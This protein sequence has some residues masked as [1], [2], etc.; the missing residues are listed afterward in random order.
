M[1]LVALFCA[2]VLVVSASATP[3][4]SA[5]RYTYDADG[6]LSG[7][8]DP[9]A[10]AA[11]FE[12]DAV[13]NLL[14]IDRWAVSDLRVMQ[15]TPSAGAVGDTVVIEGTG[16]EPVPG[17]NEV[18]FNGTEATVSSASE[19]KLVVEVPASASTGP[20]SVE[21]AAGTAS[22][23]SPF[24]VIVVQP[25]TISG[26]SPTLVADGATT[27]VTGTN[28]K[29]AKTD[30]SVA[31]NRTRASIAQATSTTLDIEAPGF[32]A[33]GRVGVTT[34]DGHATGPYLFIPPEGYLTSEVAVT[35]TIPFGQATPAA[36]ASN[37]KIALLVFEGEANDRVSLR[38]L[39]SGMTGTAAILAPNGQSLASVTVSNG[40]ARFMDSVTLPTDGTYTVLVTRAGST[41][42][43]T[44][45]TLY[46]VGQDVTAQL[47]PSASGHAAT[48]T[49]TIPGQNLRAEVDVAEG[50]RFFFTMTG[51]GAHRSKLLG[52]DGST[53]V[54]SPSQVYNTNIYYFDT[55]R[56][57]EAGTYT[58]LV[59]P[60]DDSL[61]GTTVTAH[62]VAADEVREVSPIPA[63]DS[64]A[65]TLAIGQ[66]GKMTFDGEAG[67]KL[68]WR[69][70]GR[71]P[72]TLAGQL[73]LRNSAGDTVASE[74][75]TFFQEPVALPADGE[76]TLEVDPSD[77]KAGTLTAHL[78]D[79]P[80]DLTAEL[81]PIASG[82]SETLTPAAPGQNL[83]AQ[84]EVSE[85]DR[86]LVVLAGANIHR[87]T[88]L[89]PSGAVLFS[90]PTAAS[91]YYLY[92]TFEAPDDGLYTVTVDPDKESVAS[93]TISVYAVPADDVRE[94]TPTPSGA[95][96][97]FDLDPGQSG[98]MIFDGTAGQKVSW[99]PSGLSPTSLAGTVRLRDSS[100][101]VISSQSFSSFREP[102]TLPA[103][104]EYTLE[105]DP[106]T[107]QTGSL[108]VRLH[109]VPADVTAELDPLV[110]GDAETLT[111]LAPGQ[112]LRA[113]FDAT[114]G[115]RVLITLSGGAAS[116][117]K[118]LRPDGSVLVNSPT[119]NGSL[120]H[121]DTLT[122]PADGT[123]TVTV[124]PQDDSV[125]GTTVTAYAVPADDVRAVTPTP[126]GAAETFALDPGQMGRMTFTGTAGQK[127]SW[128]V[129][130]MTP[131]SLVGSVRLRNAAGG[132]V[133]SQSLPDFREPVTL[134]ANGEYTV[135][136]D[137]R[138]SESGTLTL[139]LHDVPT[140]VTATLT[141]TSTGDTET[142]APQAPGQNLRAEFAATA[143]DRFLVT[144]TGAN[145]SKSKV[146]RPDGSV[147][148]TSWGTI[149]GGR[150]FET[151]T[152]PTAGTHAVAVD[153]DADSTASTTITVYAVPAEI[154]GTLT[155]T[156]PGD[157]IPLTTTVGQ[158][159]ALTF[160]GTA[161]NKVAVQT[162]ASDITGSLQLKRPNGTVQASLSIASGSTSTTSTQT[163]ATTGTYTIA[164]DP[165]SI[166]AGNVTATLFDRTGL[167]STTPTPPATTFASYQLPRAQLRTVSDGATF[168]SVEGAKKSRR[169]PSTSQ[170][171]AKTPTRSNMNG[172]RD[173]PAR[174]A[175]PANASPQVPSDALLRSVRSF[176]PVASASWT[177]SRDGARG[178][179]K[180]TEP[181]SPLT[182]LPALQAPPGQTALTGQVLKVNG[183]PLPNARIQLDDHDA[184]TRTDSTGRFLLETDEAG[185]AVLTVEGGTV[186][187]GL[188]SFGSYRMRIDLKAGETTALEAPVWLTK[189][190]RAGDVSIPKR[191]AKKTT[192]TNP[193]IPGFRVEIPAGS[194]IRD[195]NGEPLSRIN[196]TAIPLDRPPFPLP[197]FDVPAYFTL[198][199]AGAYLSKGAR[200]IYPNYM[201]ASP[202]QRL[203]F[204]NYDAE[205][206]GW[207]V[208]GHGRV[209]DDA[210]RMVP[211][212]GVRIWEFTGAMIGNGTGPPDVR[213]PVTDELSDGD[214]VEL[215][216]G[217]F[218]DQH[219]DL[220]VDDVIPAVAHRTYRTSDQN[221]YDFGRGT[222][223]PYDIRLWAPA[224]D[225]I[226]PNLITPRGAMVH[227]GLTNPGASASDRVFKPEGI[228]GQFA[229]TVLRRTPSGFDLE[230]RDGRVYV[231]GY[232][233]PL[234]AIK[235]AAGNQL[236]ITRSGGDRGRV[237][238]V[239]T[240]N[241]RWIRFSHDSS[242][243]TTRAVD[244]AGREVLYEY[245]TQNLL[246]EVT[247]VNG[248]VSTRTYN[249]DGRL[250]ELTDARGITYLENTYYGGRVI[251][252][253]TADGGIYEFDYDLRYEP[254][255]MKVEETRVT[256]PRGAVRRATFGALWTSDT[257]AYG[258]GIQQSTETQRDTETGRIT[259]VTD[260][261]D[262][263]TEFDYDSSGNVTSITE[264]AGTSEART[265]TATYSGPFDRLSS[266]EGPLGRTLDLDYD[267]RGRLTSLV[268]ATEREYLL[269]YSGTD[270]R[271]S[272]ITDPGGRV[273]EF[274][275]VAG[276][277]VAARDPLGRE[278][279]FHV[280]AAGRRTRAV[281]PLGN[282]RSFSYDDAGLLRR[283]VAPDGGS[284]EFD[285][286]ANGNLTEVT[287]ARNNVATAT[288]DNMDRIA[289]AT[290][291][292]NNSATFD[293]DVNGNL[294]SI[295]DRNGQVTTLA[296]DLL[297]RL[298]FVGYDTTG[299]PGSEQYESTV[300]YS[301]DDGDRLV[302]ADDSSTGTF[303]HAFNGF[304]QV[305]T[306]T[307]PNGSVGYDYDDAGRVSSVEVPTQPAITFAY[308]DA[309]RL[310]AV[311]RGGDAVAIGH[312]LAGRRSGVTLP[313][314]VT[315][316]YTRNALGHITG[317]DYT[318]NSLPIGD[319]RYNYGLTGQ[320]THAWGS[321]GALTLPA[322]MTA[323]Y[324][325]AN[326]RTSQGSVPM[327]YD[328]AGNL[329][330]DGDATYDWNARHELQ[331]VTR[332]STLTTFEYDPFGRRTER[333][334]GNDTTTYLHARRNVA[335]EKQNG[336]VRANLITGPA[337]DD[338]FARVTP[339]GTD[340]RLTDALGSTIAL[341][342]ALGWPADTTYEY[343]PFGETTQSGTPN[344]NPYQYTGRENDGDGL[345]HYRA[346]Y[347]QP[348]QQRFLSE[349][350]L[351]LAGGS[352]N[353]YTYA[354]NDPIGKNDPLGLSPFS[355]VFGVGGYVDRVTPDSVNH[356]SAG[357]FDGFFVGAPSAYFKSGSWGS[358][359]SCGQFVGAVG[360][361]ASL[362]IGITV[363]IVRAGGGLIG[364]GIAG[365]GWSGLHAARGLNPGIG[366]EDLAVSGL[367]G[368]VGGGA[369]G[370]LAGAAVGGGVS[371]NVAA[372]AGGAATSESLALSIALGGDGGSVGRPAKC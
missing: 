10:G 269:A 349:D 194:E 32:T 353:P 186:T 288:Y 212:K 205:G 66:K 190:D 157:A 331:A 88:L 232:F 206:D 299:S 60:L 225:A 233:T 341:T 228:Q 282:A 340:S 43:T 329:T 323:T 161:G 89:R 366:T 22:S 99:K 61:V 54:S 122:I 105:V 78:H 322:P 115:D 160:A 27:T 143:G 33:S 270:T 235:D 273:H 102:V 58:V 169:R 207:H 35:G 84:F 101:A 41:G 227:F 118:L 359:H 132:Q 264:M 343:G 131:S 5:L 114:A 234:L 259:R 85:G 158:G 231:F 209:S 284:T 216:T 47:D 26:I 181:P 239:T 287:D 360:G 21:T 317:I 204:W 55:H 257:Y 71:S 311:G 70:T 62:S 292:L 147:L 171:P 262:R 165:G 30:N 337:V 276:D 261:L 301:Y 293:H 251:R 272:T 150:Y 36:I 81:D 135:E 229:G 362:G 13:G 117:S 80:A 95:A 325:A 365:G 44:N 342:D 8:V 111:P 244:N 218:I 230:F 146:L 23:P 191:L 318:Q 314:G 53:L 240:P 141:P 320:R 266:I 369:G 29:A 355:D 333:T 237:K 167:A 319:L 286:D 336:T 134:P 306:E 291:A 290:D 155:P 162:S 56:A 7:V 86:V 19:S 28:F 242:N 352:T 119:L 40:T 75:M 152:V 125:A 183:A 316:E 363:G 223:S 20:V 42:G 283:S 241:G 173:R 310:T 313:N 295:T 219:T 236:T 203:Q 304:D 142:L 127:V 263:A 48:L 243:R 370:V 45:V 100:G 98:K 67:Q 126:S 357:L 175:R 309:D 335:Q 195:R 34:I 140:D 255:G 1:L 210:K 215:S 2:T 294:T 83:R 247:D 260:E 87:S 68:S 94:V 37:K 303:T 49:P 136:I 334:T 211:D 93:T 59:D 38:T 350:P 356:F 6:R 208:Y 174:P 238:Q 200:V 371:A 14:S 46:D 189:L 110:S 245:N 327:T 12:W 332:N 184:K 265:T 281:D 254:G 128:R 25:P 324:D 11:G 217:L 307:G 123:Y 180:T 368:A 274:D 185:P 104:G 347:Y 268:D 109:D 159:A 124:D 24:R 170:A 91:P 253:E 197:H 176:D 163:L 103:N 130:G 277:L 285:Y 178:G 144:L 196:L 16:F 224:D 137:P 305:T 116:R 367:V 188:A 72:S 280:D 52:P 326:R 120:Y 154:T 222:A 193:K 198:Q 69:A 90:D 156:V 77:I 9:A 328:D 65:F 129:S 73:R 315:Q 338:L 346:R 246:T 97:T 192:L 221:L 92:D 248:G 51:G 213:P 4:S 50:E 76:Y 214:P 271:P 64:E 300:E 202:G 148:N 63:G 17:D 297:D 278:T 345:Y 79:V 256:S 339:G 153:P 296:Y 164:V 358:A 107:N 3:P 330:D 108:T 275:Y 179:W 139:H 15:V 312:D 348:D 249:G 220:L 361:A 182:D 321:L 166:Q 258:E 39:G 351:G 267:S 133:A 113:E 31:V 252:Q 172:R 121:Y 168:K 151:F 82:D 57:A 364:G 289:S 298:E 112:N 18:R 201:D 354:A 344:D 250:T 149:S 226:E 302:E 74:S 199:P 372:A 177:P 106:S 138:T 96:E 279:R 187:G 308:D 145:T